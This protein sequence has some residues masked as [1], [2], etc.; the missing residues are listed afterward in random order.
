V[1]TICVQLDLP[2]ALV[3]VRS[4]DGEDLVLVNPDVPAT[5]L[6]ALAEALLREHEREAL[7]EYLAE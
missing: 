1:P 5:R 4:G 2:A 7:A 3:L 6:L